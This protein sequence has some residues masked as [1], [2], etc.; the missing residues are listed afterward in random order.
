MVFFFVAVP[1]KD[2]TDYSTDEEAKNVLDRQCMTINGRQAA[3]IY[4]VQ[5]GKGWILLSRS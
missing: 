5:V 2:K 3:E 4:H 1:L